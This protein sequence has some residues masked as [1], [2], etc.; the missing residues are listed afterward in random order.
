MVRE[1]GALVR[2]GLTTA[3]CNGHYSTMLVLISVGGNV[4]HEFDDGKRAL[5]VAAEYG[6]LQYGTDIGTVQL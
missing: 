5:T 4:E 1:L 6:Q 2:A 3:A